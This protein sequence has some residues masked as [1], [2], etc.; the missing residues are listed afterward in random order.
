MSAPNLFLIYVN[1]TELSTHF[2]SDLFDIEP[3]M[4]TPHYVSFDIAPGVLFALWSD[5]GDDVTPTTPRSSE[6]GLMVPTDKVSID[7]VFTEWKAKDIQ[8]VEEPHDAVFGRTFVISDPD[9]NLVRVS[10]VD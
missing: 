5:R 6:L 2:Y 4:V 10:P 8:V 7:D 1:D 3:T 9:G